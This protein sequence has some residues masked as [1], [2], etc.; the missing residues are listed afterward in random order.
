MRPFELSWPAA[1]CDQQP[2]LTG[3]SLSQQIPRFAIPGGVQKHNDSWADTSL[4]QAQ[5]F[6]CWERSFS[7]VPCLH[8][9]CL[10]V[11]AHVLWQ[12]WDKYCF[13]HCLSVE[14]AACH[15]SLNFDKVSVLLGKVH[16]KGLTAAIDIMCECFPLPP[17]M[18]GGAMFEWMIDKGRNSA[19][20]TWW[21]GCS[22][23][24]SVPCQNLPTAETY[25]YWSVCN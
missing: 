4:L 19:P 22:V 16:T 18:L 21:C 25:K 2:P 11:P 12:I 20:G 13:L 1:S 17:R 9:F 7:Q 14:A 15:I 23:F 10:H 8:C 5:S 24:P 3:T 6:T